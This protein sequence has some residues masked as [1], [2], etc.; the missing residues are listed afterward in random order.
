M[1]EG[2]H[3]ST[4]KRLSVEVTIGGDT[5]KNDTHLLVIMCVRLSQKI[6]LI[7]LSNRTKSKKVNGW[8][9]RTKIVRDY[10]GMRLMLHMPSIQY[11]H[12]NVNLLGLRHGFYLFVQCIFN[13]RDILSQIT[14]SFKQNTEFSGSY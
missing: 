6:G 2:G 3:K 1:L 9:I 12:T 13:T 11:R 7:D 10:W 8:K 4:K 14:F 5:T